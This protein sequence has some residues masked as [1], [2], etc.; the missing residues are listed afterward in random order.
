MNMQHGQRSAFEDRTNR[1][2]G[3]FTPNGSTLE[4]MGAHLV[5]SRRKNKIMVP[6]CAII[7]PQRY[8]KDYEENMEKNSKKMEQ[9]KKLVQHKEWIPGGKTLQ[10]T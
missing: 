10:K 5:A 1:P 8:K 7:I 4:E 2:V 3:I 9:M 6:N